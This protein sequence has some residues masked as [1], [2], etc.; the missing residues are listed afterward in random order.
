MATPAK[1]VSCDNWRMWWINARK[2]FDQFRKWSAIKALLELAGVWK[3]V[4]LGASVVGGFLLPLFSKLDP[5][6]RVLVLLL[7]V[8]LA[9][10][11]TLFLVALRR[12]TKSQLPVD[13]GND[14]AIPHDR[15]KKRYIALAVVLVLLAVVGAIWGPRIKPPVP[16]P[17]LPT[18]MM[19]SLG[20]QM[21]EAAVAPTS[22]PAKRPERVSQAR[23]AGASSRVETPET[24]EIASTPQVYGTQHIE[25]GGIGYQANGPNPRI[26]IHP[27]VPARALIP[28]MSDT[29]VLALR[30][31]L[32]VSSGKPIDISLDGSNA[33][34]VLAFSNALVKA[35]AQA[36][37]TIGSFYGDEIGG[38]IVNADGVTYPCKHP[39]I[40]FQFGHDRSGD[41]SILSAKLKNLDII[42]TINSCGSSDPEQ[43]KVF[44]SQLN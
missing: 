10:A 35:I 17:P 22:T 40:T 31:A 20:P 14:P 37:I 19:P 29:D 25:S 42:D 21:P 33:D 24:K 39:G 41:Y 5:A 26:D 9:L 18:R 6:L 2:A 30:D 8:T 32:A 27:T 12:V 28:T 38:G 11:S 4:V 44:I 43:L 3:W 34:D 23:K 13:A 7:A 1:A 15:P 36:H 16:A